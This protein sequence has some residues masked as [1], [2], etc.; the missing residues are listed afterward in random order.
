MAEIQKQQLVQEK[1]S[2]TEEE[3]FKK[4]LDQA[5]QAGWHLL[6]KA[7]KRIKSEAVCRQEFMPK[8]TL[9]PEDVANFQLIAGP[10]IEL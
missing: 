1:E 5:L 10:E 7:C 8:D 2:M 6:R 4:T 3:Q 9:T